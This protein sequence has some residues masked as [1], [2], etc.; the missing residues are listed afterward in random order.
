MMLITHLIAFRDNILD[1]EFYRMMD[2]KVDFL[3]NVLKAIWKGTYFSSME[4]VWE[5]RQESFDTVDISMFERT[6]QMTRNQII[7]GYKDTAEGAIHTENDLAEDSSRSTTNSTTII[8]DI[9]GVP[10]RTAESAHL[11]PHAPDCASL[12]YHFVSLGTLLMGS[13]HR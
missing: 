10:N 2:R 11:M 13:Y 8:L 7:K 6:Y 3:Q 4:D 9:F 12:W 5:S 1:F